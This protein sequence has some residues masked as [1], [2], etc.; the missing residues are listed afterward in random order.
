MAGTPAT[1][2]LTNRAKEI[3]SEDAI[4]VA[5]LR[6]AGAILLGKTNV[7]QLMIQHECD[8]PLYGRTNNPW[9]LDRTSG[10]ST[11]GEAALLAA[12][13][14]PLGLGSDLGGSIRIPCHFCGV[15]GLKP[16]SR[17]L[18][19]RGSLRT[20]RGMD[21]IQAQPGPMA[22][23][24]GDLELMFRVLA[25][26]QPEWC[27]PDTPPVAW[28][29]PSEVSV[30]GLRVGWWSD[31]GYFPAS[32]AIRR[33]TEESARALESL[34]C[35]VEPWQPKDVRRGMELYF[36]LVSADGAADFS[37]WLEGA[38]V[39]RRVSRLVGLGGTSR[40]LRPLS[41][42]LMRQFGEPWL[43]DLFSSAGPRSADEYWC[44]IDELKSLR[45][46]FL[47]EATRFDALLCPAYALPAF[48]HG[49]GLDLMPA[50]SYSFFINLLDVPAGIIPASRVRPGEEELPRQANDTVDQAARKAEQGS[51][52]LPVGVQ[53]VAQPWREDVL[54]RV[55]EAL[56]A[57]FQGTA[58]YPH[59]PG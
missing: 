12:R 13:G 21:A 35:V 54:L 20:M 22:R 57:H 55:M 1:L 41:G 14:S 43:A 10:G 48:P 4:L 37:R 36:A 40:W 31:D 17:R 2:G 32:P 16:T 49:R 25:E 5:R 18:P 24:V 39:D 3:A 46:R 28:R 47:Q 38:T 45:N 59:F 42:W 34:G 7:P 44:L 30:A 52:G 29:A 53:V 19:R 6:R 23:S 8:N 27:D 9:D 58:D 15:S 56:E 11:G 51:A 50:A 33:A 26:G